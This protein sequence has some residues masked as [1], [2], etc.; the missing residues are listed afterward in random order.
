V[1]N[2]FDETYRTALGSALV[3]GTQTSRRFLVGTVGAPRTLHV[4]YSYAF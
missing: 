2:L 3:D 1:E 4:S